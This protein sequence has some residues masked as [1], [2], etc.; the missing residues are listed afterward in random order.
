MKIFQR[1]ITDEEIQVYAKLLLA[2][3]NQWANY[4]GPLIRTD[5]DCYEL[6]FGEEILNK[7][8]SLSPKKL[9]KGLRDLGLI[10][11][12]IYH[13]ED[14][15]NGISNSL[16][17]YTAINTVNVEEG[18]SVLA[19]A[20]FGNEIHL[21]NGTGQILYVETYNWIDIGCG[22]LMIIR[23]N[24][25]YDTQ[26]KGRQPHNAYEIINYANSIIGDRRV[27]FVTEKNSKYRIYGSN[28]NI[29]RMIIGD[30]NVCEFKNLP[31]GRYMVNKVSETKSF[32][33]LR[34]ERILNR[35][36]GEFEFES[37]DFTFN[38]F[39]FPSVK[40]Y[41]EKYMGILEII[42]S[43]TNIKDA[44]LSKLLSSPKADFDNLFDFSIYPYLPFTLRIDLDIILALFIRTMYAEYETRINYDFLERIELSISGIHQ[45]RELI[46]KEFKFPEQI[47]QCFKIDLTYL[48]SSIN[49]EISPKRIAAIQSFIME[50]KDRIKEVLF[51]FP[52]ILP[53]AGPEILNNRE[54]V[55]FGLKADHYLINYLPEKYKDDPE[56]ILLAAKNNEALKLASDRLKNDYQFVKKMISLNGEHI[57]HAGNFK[58]KRDLVKLALNDLKKVHLIPEILAYYTTDK[59]IAKLYIKSNPYRIEDIADEL[60]QNKSFIIDLIEDGYIHYSHLFYAGKKEILSEYM[61]DK[62]LVKKMLHN[63]PKDFEKLPDYFKSDPIILTPLIAKKG[64]GSYIKFGDEKFKN[65]KKNFMLAVSNNSYVLEYGNVEQKNNT[66]IVLAALRNDGT[67]LK[68]ASEEIKNNK[69]IVSAAVNN[70]G[71]ALKYAS[72]ELKNNK[73]IVLAAVRN[74]GIAL[75]FASEELKNNKEIVSAAVNNKKSA[76]K[77]SSL[78]IK[79]DTK[80]L[81]ENS[82]DS[83]YLDHCLDS[84]DLPF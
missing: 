70:D 41:I 33:N 12:L 79:S 23:I 32:L 52:N 77:Y 63:N 80:F 3:C 55:M 4:A 40:L 67:A 28:G 37:D 82:I 17:I 26:V 73:E 46:N 84:D 62:E 66:E 11:K 27:E 72:E 43:S 21:L 14:E 71:T 5:N 50:N 16:P 54:M 49:D 53:Y 81:N 44:A 13:I 74:D 25:D 59:E 31:L 83:S 51:L 78:D 24:D 38:Y 34:D 60:L 19:E 7:I 57:T 61:H 69:E 10:P 68:Y 9:I 56:I 8:N 42:N 29:D 30:G 48:N 22:N 15:S 58:F 18:G 76:I 75:E 36:I 35:S 45:L 64:Y 6:E 65:D 47:R 2:K 20:F 1:N 39:I